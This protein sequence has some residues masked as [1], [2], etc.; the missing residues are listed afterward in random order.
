ME[1]LGVASSHP[2]QARDGVFGNMDETSGCPYPTS[3]VQ[4]VDDGFRLFFRDPG[5]EQGRTAAFGELLAAC[6]ATQEPDAVLAVDFAYGEMV[7]ARETKLLAGGVDT[8]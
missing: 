2:E 4:M 6:P 7:L 8:R 3:F 1:P 5:V